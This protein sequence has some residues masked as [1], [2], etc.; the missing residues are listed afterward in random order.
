MEFVSTAPKL[1]GG[2]Y[3]RKRPGRGAM[4]SLGF[5]FSRARILVEASF[6]DPVF[7]GSATVEK[8]W[9][10]RRTFAVVRLASGRLEERQL[11]SVHIGGLWSR[12]EQGSRGCSRHV[13]CGRKDMSR[14]S[15]VSDGSCE[16][17]ADSGRYGDVEWCLR[18]A[19]GACRCR[20]DSWYSI[21]RCAV[22]LA[23]V[24]TYRASQTITRK[25]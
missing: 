21:R 12:V 13:G 24:G 11:A 2:T 9:R 23:V 4:L 19:A 10:I 16:R 8:R 20:I 14:D 1:A 25:P 3:M 22:S 6:L 17:V 5:R 18:W 7:L 15:R